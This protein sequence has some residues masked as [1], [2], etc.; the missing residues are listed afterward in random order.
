[1]GTRRSSLPPERW[2][3]N[4]TP[5]GFVSISASTATSCTPDT[6]PCWTLYWRTWSH[7][8]SPA[9]V[10]HSCRRIQ[11]SLVECEVK[12]GSTK[13]IFNFLTMI[14]KRSAKKKISYHVTWEGSQMFLKMIADKINFVS[15]L[16]A[17]TVW[18]TEWRVCSW[19]VW[20]HNESH[21][22]SSCL[23]SLA[24]RASVWQGGH[25]IITQP[26][27]SKHISALHLHLCLRVWVFK[28]CVQLPFLSQEL[29]ADSNNLS[30]SSDVGVLQSMCAPAT[31]SVGWR[32][33]IHLI[34][35]NLDGKLLG[36][37]NMKVMLDDK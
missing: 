3:Q 1:M 6:V 21:Y 7:R 18:T 8:R 35:T 15:V 5:T 31:L 20:L 28:I 4:P 13:T 29:H 37:G 24:V 26:H 33:A 10:S 34:W 9:S 17:Q 2:R 12:E 32:V 14:L 16:G 30:W 11:A 25:N 23:Y 19:P 22:V 36:A 27:T